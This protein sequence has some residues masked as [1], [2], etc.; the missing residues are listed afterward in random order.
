[1]Y[2]VSVYQCENKPAA[3]RAVLD[4]RKD[5]LM[6]TRD[7]ERSARQAIKTGLLGNA[8]QDTD[9]EGNTVERVFLGTVFALTPSGK[10]YTPFASGN[11]ISCPRCKGEGTLPVDHEPFHVRKPCPHCHGIG[12]REAYEDEVF[13]EELERAASKAGWYIESG[14]GDPCDIFMVRVIDTPDEDDSE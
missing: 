5:D 4:N 6:N 13:N 3:P 1:M 14:E 9:M 2:L 7:I 10:Y 11:V 12:S 8:Y